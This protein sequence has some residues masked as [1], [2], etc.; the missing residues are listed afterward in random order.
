MRFWA[1]AMLWL[2]MGGGAAAAEPTFQE[3]QCVTAGWQRLQVDA[4]GL[5]RTVLWKAP[6]A[7]WSRGALVVLHGGGGQHAN[8]CV[9]NAPVIAAQVRFTDLALAQ[10]FAV[11]LPDSSDRVTDNEGKL[12]GKVWDDEVRKRPN[13]DLPF[14]RHLLSVSIPG[15]RPPGGRAEVF[16]AGHSSGGFMTVRL[17]SGLPE[18]VTAFAIVASGDPYG[19][20]RDCTPR[21][22]DRAN[23][24]GAGFDNDTRRQIIEPGACGAPPY[25]NE[26]PWDG[27]AQGAKP[28]WRAFHHMEDGIN[29]ASCVAR[30][31]NQLRARGFPETAAFRLSGGTRSAGLH[32]WLDAYNQP[33]LDFFSAQVR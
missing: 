2:A 15:L 14:V 19:W 11:F 23:V 28:A 5:Q 4:A 32:L 25:A 20:H 33:L 22:T 13:L 18:Q 3:K 26:K 10:G 17:A 30:V 21:R 29:D 12:C 8:F 9:A 27:P 7:G 16:L 1:L 24:F 6:A 31:S